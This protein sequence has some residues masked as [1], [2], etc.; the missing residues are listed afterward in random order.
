MTTTRRVTRNQKQDDA[1]SCKTIKTD[2]V[3]PRS[4]LNHDVLLLVM[5]QLGVIDFVAFSG[6]CKSWR[7]VALTNRKTFMASKPPMLMD[8][9]PRCNNKDRKCRLEDY[10]GRVYKTTLTH[11][12]GMYYIGLTCGYLILFRMK[13]NKDFWL[14]NPI[15]R[16]ELNFPPAPWMPDYVSDI[17]CVLVFS[18]S[19]S[20]L[21]FVVLAQN[22]IWFSIADEGTW[23]YVSTFDLKFSQSDVARNQDSYG[24]SGHHI[25]PAAYTGEELGFFFSGVGHGAAVKPEFW[26]EAWSQYKRYDVDNGGG[27]GRVF[28]A[29][30]EWY[31]PDECLN[32]NLLDESS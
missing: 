27:H 8:I 7:S 24:Y 14:V 20:K 13:T 29:I 15:T 11:S 21:V 9:S 31:F 23:K 10:E 3:G 6:V 5:M 1:S 32:V 18:P 12:A 22:Q 28:P 16:H 2:D 26:A 4:S 17:S 19:V 25:L 30:D